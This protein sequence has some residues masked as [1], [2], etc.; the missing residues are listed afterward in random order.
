MQ[1]V[2]VASFIDHVGGEKMSWSPPVQPGNEA[3]GGSGEDNF[4]QWS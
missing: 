1:R 2:V 3:K 4:R